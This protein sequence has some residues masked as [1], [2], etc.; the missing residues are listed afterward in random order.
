MKS[1]CTKW[2]SWKKKVESEKMKWINLNK[3]KKKKEEETLQLCG[4]SKI[5]V[6]CVSVCSRMGRIVVRLYR[7]SHLIIIIHRKINANRQ[8]TIPY[9]NQIGIG[10]ALAHRVFTFVIHITSCCATHLSSTALFSCHSSN[11]FTFHGIIGMRSLSMQNPFDRVKSSL[12]MVSLLASFDR[13][14]PLLTSNSSSSSP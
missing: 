2:M 8:S 10:S 6:H 11:S 1:M 7:I 4:H 12:P 5:A 14:L 3:L 9:V 13:L